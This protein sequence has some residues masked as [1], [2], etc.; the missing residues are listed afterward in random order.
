MIRMGDYCLEPPKC[1]RLPYSP[2]GL[3][4][5]MTKAIAGL[6]GGVTAVILIQQLLKEIFEEKE[7]KLR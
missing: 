2:A 3:S 1:R 6:V 5:N 4:Q 7:V